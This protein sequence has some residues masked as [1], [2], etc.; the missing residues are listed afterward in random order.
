MKLP[1]VPVSLPAAFGVG[2]AYEW[3]ARSSAEDRASEQNES[4][5]YPG[6]HTLPK[7]VQRHAPYTRTNSRGTTPT[8]INNPL[9]VL[10]EGNYTRAHWRYLIS[11]FSFLEV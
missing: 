4:I 11:R 7:S 2:I 10:S 9:P 6:A 3:S 8:S 5:S 1:L